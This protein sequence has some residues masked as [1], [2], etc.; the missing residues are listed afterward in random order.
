MGK[1]VRTFRS[2]DI[3]ET[4]L[5]PRVDVVGE[6]KAAHVSTTLTPANDPVFTCDQFVS[7]NSVPMWLI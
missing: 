2:L 6:A 3:S 4:D 1:L 5:S 7:A